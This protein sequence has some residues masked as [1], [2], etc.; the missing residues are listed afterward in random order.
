MSRDMTVLC[1]YDVKRWTGPSRVI[2]SIDPAYVNFAIR[3]EKLTWDTSNFDT[4]PTRELLHYHKYDFTEKKKDDQLIWLNLQKMLDDLHHYFTQAHIFLIEKQQSFTFK[5]KGT[6]NNS[7]V[8]RV[9]GHTLGVLV[10]RYGNRD[11]FPI[12]AEVNPKLKA[13]M[14][15]PEKSKLKYAETKTEAEKRVKE[16]FI[17]WGDTA[18]QQILAA[19]TKKDDLADVV[20]QMEGWCK[21]YIS[22]IQD[23]YNS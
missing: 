9:F 23:S 20:C 7:K 4:P 5:N 14:L 10:T 21:R 2:V 13:K 1:E 19:E 17:S 11:L 22:I 16:F 12:I 18:S 15:W 6:V 8:I 3:I